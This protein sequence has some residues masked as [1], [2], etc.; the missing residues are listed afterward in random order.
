MWQAHEYHF[1]FS[2]GSSSGHF[3]LMPFVFFGV[4]AGLFANGFWNYRKLR[5]IED[6]PRIAI[7]SVPM[8]LVHVRGKAGGEFLL[9]SPVTRT[10]CYYYQVRLERWEEQGKHPGW[11]IVHTATEGRVF[12]LEDQTGKV[13]VNPQSAEYDLPEAYC[14]AFG[15]HARGG[16]YLDPSLNLAAGPSEEDLRAYAAN[17]DPLFKQLGQAVAQVEAKY[18]QAS[19]FSKRIVER[20]RQAIDGANPL[21]GHGSYRI[22][23]H[24]VVAEREYD[25]IGTCAQNPATRRRRRPEYHRQGPE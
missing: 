9:T 6:T 23:E 11:A 14:G 16:P 1:S 7:R 22:T 25:V 18:A 12:S 10:P 17:T 20:K 24:C 15:P 5:V 3:S 8:G 4:G 19:G 21:T 13:L 2:V